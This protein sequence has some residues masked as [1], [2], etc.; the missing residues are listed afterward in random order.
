MLTFLSIFA[1]LIVSLL[2]LGSFFKTVQETLKSNQE[3]ELIHHRRELK[4]GKG[5]LSLHEE[6]ESGKISEVPNKPV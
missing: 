2:F 6:R 3:W 5:G 4:E 1:L